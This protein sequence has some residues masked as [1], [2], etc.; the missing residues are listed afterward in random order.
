MKIMVIIGDDGRIAGATVESPRF[1]SRIGYPS[2]SLVAGEGQRLVEVD[3]PGE[4][5]PG[6]DAGSAEIEQ[7]LGEL[8][9]RVAR[10]KDGRRK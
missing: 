9:K 5:I 4:M 6:P 8:V 2:A 7:Y 3:V 1:E 10:T